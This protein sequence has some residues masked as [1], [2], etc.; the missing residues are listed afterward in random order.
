[1]LSFFSS[2]VLAALVFCEICHSLLQNVLDILLLQQVT[3][4][5][6]MHTSPADVAMS[7]YKDLKMKAESI[8]SPIATESFDKRYDT[9]KPRSDL[10]TCSVMQFSMDDL[11]RKTQFKFT[12]LPQ[13]K[14]LHGQIRKTR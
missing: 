4:L 12:K 9:R 10:K 14:T 1:M 3:G 5:L 13:C 2:L 7:S 6:D 8:S 11:R